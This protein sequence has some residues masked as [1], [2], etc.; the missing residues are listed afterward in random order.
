MASDSSEHV[1]EAFD[2][3]VFSSYVALI[4]FAAPDPPCSEISV[5]RCSLFRFCKFT[6]GA[7]RS[8]GGPKYSSPRGR[9]RRIG[10]T[11]YPVR[12]AAYDIGKVESMRWG[13][14][15]LPSMM[16]VR[17]SANS[18]FISP[19]LLKAPVGAIFVLRSAVLAGL[20]HR[21]SKTYSTCALNEKRVHFR[22][23]L[24]ECESWLKSCLY[25]KMSSYG[26][27]DDRARE[28]QVEMHIN[29]DFL[30]AFEACIT[31]ENAL[32]QAA[33]SAP[34]N[35]LEMVFLPADERRLRKVSCLSLCILRGSYLR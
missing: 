25:F 30:R 22:I 23:L 33:P 20:M 11:P 14:G 29:E 5:S 15:R 26:L 10:S 7:R 32:G 21:G 16:Q 8:S 13:E 34:R 18:D 2:P 6:G 4:L 19:E 12:I 3:R 27:E 28:R 17:A 35:L 9:W 24:L 31:R 1:P